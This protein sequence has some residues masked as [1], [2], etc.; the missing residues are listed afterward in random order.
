[1][2]KLNHPLKILHFLGALNHGGIE[3]WLLQLLNYYNPADFHFTF[4]CLSGQEGIYASEFKALGA[5]IL[6]RPLPSQAWQL[7]PF[8]NQLFT[9]VQPHI[10]HSHVHHFS[11]YILRAAAK[12]GI[13][14]RLAHSY[15]APPTAPYFS[16][17]YWYEK[18]M[19]LW[20]K[21]YKT[22]GLGNSRQSMQALFGK[23]WAEKA[24]CRLLYC[25]LQLDSFS[26]PPSTPHH[27]FHPFG[28]PDKAP[29]IGHIGRFTEAKNH[30]FILHLAQKIA[31]KQPDIWFLLVGDGP[32][33]PQLMAQAAQLGLKQVI[34]TGATKEILPYL[35]R[36]NLFLF[37]SLWEG[38]PQSVLEAQAAGIPCLCAD[39]ITTEVQV[40]PELV[41]FLSL[42]YPLE[43]W[44]THC[45]THLNS[46]PIPHHLAWQK[47][48]QSPFNITSSAE[49]L[50]AY[51]QQ[52]TI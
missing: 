47:M 13:P 50:L 4:V 12:F 7:T 26:T 16:K 37:P 8:L 25:G 45:L 23:N 15:T 35:F 24:D 32:L 28:L 33:R 3:T 2:N 48:A 18:L 29:V 51:Y 22:L 21:Q 34:F 30:Q 42:Q 44:I 6:A 46:P 36:M 9:E 10:V 49:Q 17:R 14:G 1:M 41:H 27:F 40:I 5:T 38:L 11:G 31:E 20:I 39:T 19:T 43:A 52:T